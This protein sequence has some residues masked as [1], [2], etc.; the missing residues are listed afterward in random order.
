MDAGIAALL[1]ALIGAV[2]GIAGS[3]IVAIIA[4][5]SEE[6]KHLRQLAFDAGQKM[7]ALHNEIAKRAA[8]AGRKT[9]VDPLEAYILNAL[10]FSRIIEEGDLDQETVLKKWREQ[11]SIAQALHAEIRKKE[12]P[13]NQA[14]EPTRGTGP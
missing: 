13:A 6:K 10:V 1:G 11:D 5:R 4:K 14:P 12:K 2:A 7:W 8:D 9:G 3:V